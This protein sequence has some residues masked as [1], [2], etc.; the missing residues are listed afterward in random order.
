MRVF[1]RCSERWMVQTNGHSSG[2]NPM[3]H[4]VEFRR[5]DDRSGKS[6]PG[7]VVLISGGNVETLSEHELCASL[8]EGLRRY[9]PTDDTED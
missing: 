2:W 3:N 5:C 7:Q 9:G 8:E 4:S 1:E 6:V